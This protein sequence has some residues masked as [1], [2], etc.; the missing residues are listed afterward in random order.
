MCAIKRLRS[1]FL[2]C[3]LTLLVSCNANNA[4]I[5]TVSTQNSPTSTALSTGPLPTAS[6]PQ[7]A[8]GIEASTSIPE[9]LP[10]ETPSVYASVT[11][12]PSASASLLPTSIPTFTPPRPTVP[13]SPAHSQTFRVLDD[14]EGCDEFVIPPF[15]SGIAPQG[16]K[17]LAYSEY[18]TPMP[19]Q[20]SVDQRTGD[21]LVLWNYFDRNAYLNDNNLI[22]IDPK[23]NGCFDWPAWFAYNPEEDVWS[24]DKLLNTKGIDGIG[25]DVFGSPFERTY[26]WWYLNRHYQSSIDPSLESRA[27]MTGL[28]RDID[29]IAGRFWVLQMIDMPLDVNGAADALGKTPGIPYP[30]TLVRSDGWMD[31]NTPRR[32]WIAAQNG[33][34]YSAEGIYF[35]ESEYSDY[36]L[37]IHFYSFLVPFAQRTWTT[38]NFALKTGWF[39]GTSLEEYIVPQVVYSKRD[40]RLYFMRRNWEGD[41]NQFR[42]I[43]RIP[44]ATAAP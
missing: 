5:H 26:A 22:C 34:A 4:N 16:I 44:R 27:Y 29:P 24:F 14:C 23:Q 9:T 42:S 13:P 2:S 1:C 6:V 28:V 11:P 3:T 18:N 36:M 40:G 19:L 43:V 21:I 17:S 10:H 35:L 20:L 25:R 38:R 8:P 12:E 37:R 31:P 15:G 39:R 7:I 32:A 33:M 41:A 30:P